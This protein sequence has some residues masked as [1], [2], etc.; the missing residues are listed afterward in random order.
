VVAVGIKQAIEKLVDSN[1]PSL[2]PFDAR[3]LCQIDRLDLLERKRALGRPTRQRRGDLRIT[4]E[5]SCRPEA[6]EGL[7]VF[8]CSRD[9][10]SSHVAITGWPETAMFLSSAFRTLRALQE[11][12]DESSV[13]E[14]VAISL[15]TPASH[16]LTHPPPCFLPDPSFAPTRDHPTHPDAQAGPGPSASPTTNDSQSLTLTSSE[17][18][19]PNPRSSRR[20]PST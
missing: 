15:A 19:G 16:F 13:R 1:P 5:P 4:K 20:S 12:A 2:P 17:R 7:Q 3:K 10:P 9:I 14:G 6:G 11:W 8:S 18:S